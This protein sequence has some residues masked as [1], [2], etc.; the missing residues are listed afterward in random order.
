MKAAA[1]FVLVATLITTGNAIAGG[2]GEIRPQGI[3][4]AAERSQDRAHALI[5][6]AEELELFLSAEPAWSPLRALSDSGRRQFLGSLDFSD[7]GLASY[8][9]AGLQGADE[10]LQISILELFGEQ[11]SLT[12]FAGASKD[13][14]SSDQSVRAKPPALHPQPGVDY[15]GYKCVG[16]GT[17]EQS[18]RDT[19]CIGDNC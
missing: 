4:A 3:D 11:A 2:G 14:P 19:I 1:L 17:C 10:H 8:S 12:A 15:P 6:S 7:Q 16:K 5:R 9:I 18:F 13:S